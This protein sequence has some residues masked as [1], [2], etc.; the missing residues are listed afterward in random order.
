M[1]LYL[2]CLKPHLVS[3]NRS[4]IFIHACLPSSLPIPVSLVLVCPD[5]SSSV[6]LSCIFQTPT[7]TCAVGHPQL[8]L[9][10]Y[11]SHQAARKVNFCQAHCVSL[12]AQE[13]GACTSPGKLPHCPG[14]V[15]TLS[16]SQ[17]QTRART[18]YI[19]TFPLNT[20]VFM[21]GKPGK[22]RGCRG[23]TRSCPGKRFR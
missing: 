2:H 3:L 8:P 12:P 9:L 20:L 1:P 21:N 16:L 18:L 23:A 22:M 5:S 15:C 4:G 17:I 11:H 10:L 6:V 14:H 7:T 13:E 19:S